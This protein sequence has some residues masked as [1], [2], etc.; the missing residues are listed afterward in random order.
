MRTANDSETLAAEADKYIDCYVSTD[1]LEVEEYFLEA[2]GLEDISCFVEREHLHDE[3][4]L[5]PR[6]EDHWLYTQHLVLDLYHGSVKDPQSGLEI[7]YTDIPLREALDQRNALGFTS[8][9]KFRMYINAANQVPL[10]GTGSAPL[11]SRI[12][13]VLEQERQNTAFIN[14]RG[15]IYVHLSE[16]YC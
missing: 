12:E 3:Y 4:R 6:P 10:F 15:S 13:T 9:S 16:F 7:D 5:S 2:L 14:D 8:M 11:L 1:A